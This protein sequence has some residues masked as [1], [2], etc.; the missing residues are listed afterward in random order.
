[1]G[2]EMCIRDRSIAPNEIISRGEA[3][4]GE[5]FYYFKSNGTEKPERVKIRTPTLANI[6]AVCKMLI[7]YHIA[8]IP[9]VF[10][11]IDPCLS[12]TGRFA[13]IDERKGKSWVWDK[14]Q[15]R[16]YS[17]KYYR[18]RGLNSR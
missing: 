12:C 5:L 6:P 4:R 9:I 7:G 18:D 3:P 11:G 1:M 17:L 15:L 13:F 10:A 14:E 2:S 8:E 16:R